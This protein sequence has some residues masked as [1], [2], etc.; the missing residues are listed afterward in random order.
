VNVKVSDR[1]LSVNEIPVVFEVEDGL[2]NVFSRK[3]DD[4]LLVVPEADCEE[5]GALT[6]R[7]ANQIGPSVARC[8]LVFGDTGAEN[9]FRI[10][11]GVL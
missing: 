4:R 10:G 8:R 5:L 2:I 6:I 11:V 1:G 9:V 7:S 3:G